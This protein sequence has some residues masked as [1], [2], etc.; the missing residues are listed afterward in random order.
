MTTVRMTTVGIVEDNANMRETFREWIDATPGMRCLCACATVK[1]ALQE[2]PRCRPMVALMDIHLP[3]ESGI[4]CTS[5]LKTLLP[6]LQIV[7]VTVYKDYDLIFQAL[8][9][10]A[11]GYLLKRSSPQEVLQ[12]IRDVQ[13]GG[14]P[15][16]GEIARMVVETFHKRQPASSKVALAPR[17][18]EILDLVSKGLTNKEIADNLGLSFET[19]RNRLRYVYDK[20]H[21]HCRAEAVMKFQ[22]QPKKMVP[23]RSAPFQGDRTK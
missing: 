4:F 23:P 13:T 17:E 3:D 7:I 2:I 1:E 22:N 16:T 18:T 6:E 12:A 15:M 19:I 20:L 8:E 9:A 10:G 5:R 11:S 14:A 21:V